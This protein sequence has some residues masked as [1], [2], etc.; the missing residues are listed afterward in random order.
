[1]QWG[2]PSGPR[3]FTARFAG[4]RAK[5]T[6]H[7]GDQVVG[8][9]CRSGLQYSVMSIVKGRGA[10]VA[11]VCKSYSLARFAVVGLEPA[12]DPT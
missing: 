7:V 8:P 10:S 4:E 3:E 1:M 2:V 12:Q 6:L 5:R 11:A 9:V